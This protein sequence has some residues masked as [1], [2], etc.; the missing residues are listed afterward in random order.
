MVSVEKAFDIIM[1]NTLPLNV[2]SIAFQK[3]LGHILAEDLVADRNFPPFDRVTMDGIA[4]DFAAFKNG[5]RKFK[6]QEM[7]AAGE[8]QKTLSSEQ[9]C[10][11]IMTGG[12]LPKKTDTVIRYED[13]EIQDGIAEILVDL[14]QGQNIHK[15][16]QDKKQGELVLKQGT[17]IN[18]S[19]IALAA[20]LGKEFLNVF[21]LPK[22]AIIS[23]GDELV[24][25][26]VQPLPHQIRKSNVFAIE[27]ILKKVDAE[28]IAYFA[29]FKM[30]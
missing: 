29:L 24:E 25:V 21:V 17:K 2:R 11:E 10:I 20:S 6:I 4:I 27:T 22:I 23:S 28:I 18:A 12:V 30:E 13:V 16:G 15:E 14:K 1:Q 19:H 3:A 8:E 7:Q 26:T 5:R 9:N